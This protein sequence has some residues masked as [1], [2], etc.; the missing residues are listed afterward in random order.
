[1]LLL[2]LSIFTEK[3][4]ITKPRDS[5]FSKFIYYE[6]KEILTTRN[7]LFRQVNLINPIEDNFTQALSVKEILDELDI[8][9]DD[10]YRALSIQK[11]EGLELILVSLIIMLK[12]VWKYDRQIWTYNLFLI[13]IRQWNICANISQNLEIDVHSP[14]NKH[15]RRSLRTACIVMTP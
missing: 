5:K 14:W 10:Y 3:T 2:L 11:D 4:I 8:S 13:S 1:M 15:P 9:K 6:K 12:L 7:I